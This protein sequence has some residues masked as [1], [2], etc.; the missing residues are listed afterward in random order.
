MLFSSTLSVRKRSALCFWLIVICCMLCQNLLFVGSTLLEAWNLF[1][2]GW[3]GEESFDHSV[4]CNAVLWNKHV[5][6]M[7]HSGLWCPFCTSVP[8]FR[9]QAKYLMSSVSLFLFPLFF[10]KEDV[11]VLFS[12]AKDIFLLKGDS[13]RYRTVFSVKLTYSEM[14]RFY[15]VFNQ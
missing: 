3:A 15:F 13:C 8:F 14:Q 11:P 6:P 10:C 2:G 9:L 7:S 4:Q 5:A 1:F 12:S